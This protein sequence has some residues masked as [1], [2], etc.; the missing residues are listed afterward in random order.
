[1]SQI[2]TKQTITSHLNCLNIQH[3]TTYEVENPDRG[4]GQEQTR[5]GVA[6]L[7]QSSIYVYIQ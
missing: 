1:M 7:H 4:F 6:S 2:L 3:T 5:G